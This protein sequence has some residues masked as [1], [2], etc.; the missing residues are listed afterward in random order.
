MKIEKTERG[1]E[2]IEFKDFLRDE[3]SLQQSRRETTLLQEKLLTNYY[4][5]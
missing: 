2:L 3:C 5:V 4:A 1:F